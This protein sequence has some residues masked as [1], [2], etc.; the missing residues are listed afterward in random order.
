MVG[1]FSNPITA[2]N[3]FLFNHKIAVKIIVEKNND[4]N[5]IRRD[6]RLAF[7]Q[8]CRTTQAK[9]NTPKTNDLNKA[10]DAGRKKL[11]S[12]FGR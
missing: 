11:E 7:I 4:K 3:D 5:D 10:Q 9:I 6:V 1:K 2:P 12:I 8:F